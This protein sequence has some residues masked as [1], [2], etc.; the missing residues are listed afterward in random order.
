MCDKE[1]EQEWES[2]RWWWWSWISCTTTTHCGNVVRQAGMCCHRSILTF[3]YQVL[4]CHSIYRKIWCPI[5]SLLIS[6]LYTLKYISDIEI[7]IL[8]RIWN[9]MPLLCF[10]L[11]IGRHL[12]LDPIKLTWDFWPHRDLN[13]FIGDGYI[14]PIRFLSSTSPVSLASDFC[15]LCP[16][17]YVSCSCCCR[18]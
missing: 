16:S 7:E 13:L 1:N 3:F 9:D 18:S 10:L 5:Q 4:A 12:P 17:S 8:V 15:S 14:F 11:L 2:R 6:I